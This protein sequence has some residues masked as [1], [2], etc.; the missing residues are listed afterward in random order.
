MYEEESCWDCGGRGCETC[1]DTGLVY[2]QEAI[3]LQ[4]DAEEA[5]GD[6]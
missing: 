2:T 3:R 5:E 1:G 6:A 4:V